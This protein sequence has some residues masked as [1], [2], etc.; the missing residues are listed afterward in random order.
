MKMQV[1]ASHGGNARDSNLKLLIVLLGGNRRNNVITLHE[2][3]NYLS[4]LLHSLG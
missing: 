2:T 1:T 4:S 3:M